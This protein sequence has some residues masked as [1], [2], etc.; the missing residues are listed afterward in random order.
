MSG[1]SAAT[2]VG[3]ARTVTAPAGGRARG[4]AVAQY[5]GAPTATTFAAFSEDGQGVRLS[6]AAVLTA[7]LVFIGFVVV[8]HI[9]GRLS[10]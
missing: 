10:S 4:D 9:Y 8:L 3:G 7:S 1:L 5:R 2:K 6:P